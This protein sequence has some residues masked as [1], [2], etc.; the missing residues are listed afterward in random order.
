MKAALAINC[1]RS[2]SNLQNVMAMASVA[3]RAGAE[4][5]LF[6]EAA[7]TG[8]KNNDDPEHDLPLGQPIPGPATE[9]L[10]EIATAYGVWIA[11][12]LLEQEGDHLYDSAVLVT[13][14]GEIGLKYRRN[15]PGWHGR[16][17]D[18]QI[19]REGTEIPVAKTPLGSIAFLI[20]G[21]IFD[22]EIVARVRALKP[23]WLLFPFA[24]GFEAC[25]SAQKQ[26]DAETRA[27]Y[28]ERASATGAT[29]LMVNYLAGEGLDGDTSF[30][31]AM[32]V[33]S[34]GEVLAE[35]PL[36]RQGLIYVDLPDATENA[37]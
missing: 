27:E 31:G 13:P 33:G 11:L 23:D 37:P 21:D 34:D 1:V 30:G 2:S 26:W 17:A 7:L 20:C 24:R 35:Y 25:A 6:P 14:E 18:P 16:Q 3:A 28:V 8:L 22:D 10:V 36:E 15:H 32:V 29:T 9:A 5:I 19:Y 4:L 12:G